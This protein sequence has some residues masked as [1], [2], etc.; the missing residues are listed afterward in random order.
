MT[1]YGFVFGSRLTLPDELSEILRQLFRIPVNGQPVTVL[2]L[3]GIPSEVV[4][5][6]VSVLCRL[7]FDFALW[8]ET[9]VPLTI[10]CEEGSRLRSAR[11]AVGFRGGETRA[12]PDR[13]GGPEVRSATVCG[14][15]TAVGFG[16][17]SALGMQYHIR[18]P[19]DRA[20][21]SGHR[22]RGPPRSLSWADEVPAGF[23]QRG[24][25]RG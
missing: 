14:Y 19:D 6:V 15:T 18:V 4:N 8:N 24:G 5:V 25:D 7:T 11:Q 1:R 10:V 17:R 23:A 20:G 9:P 3:S 16:P 12:V 21:G 13:Q 22:T 2:D